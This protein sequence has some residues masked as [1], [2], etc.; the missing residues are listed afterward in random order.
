ME[1]PLEELEGAGVGVVFV[2]G[3]SGGQGG[4]DDDV[5]ITS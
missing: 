1:I 3:V 4:S 5:V 2:G